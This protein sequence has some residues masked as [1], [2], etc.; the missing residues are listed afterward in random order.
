MCLTDLGK[1]PSLSSDVQPSLPSLSSTP[2]IV[3]VLP[4]PVYPYAKIVAEYPSR[5]E[6]I[7]SYIE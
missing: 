3:Y 2:D 6:L 1:R 5:A 4:D 7:S